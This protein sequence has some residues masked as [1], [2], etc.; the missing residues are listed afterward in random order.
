MTN[1]FYKALYSFFF[2]SNQV[3]DLQNKF[4]YYVTV[5]SY[6]FGK[7]QTWIIYIYYNIFNKCFYFY[8]LYN[9]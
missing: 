2:K 9:Y 7:K 1:Y 5:I 8:Y 4:L 6:I 3:F